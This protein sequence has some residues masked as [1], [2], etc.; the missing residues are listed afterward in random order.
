M[1]IKDA[2][3][4]LSKPLRHAAVALKSIQKVQYDDVDVLFIRS[5]GVLDRNVAHMSTKV[6]LLA[7]ALI[8]GVECLIAQRTTP[9]QLY[10]NQNERVMSLLTLRLGSMG[11]ERGK[12]S[13]D[14]EEELKKAKGMS[15]R[16]AAIEYA[17]K[18]DPNKPHATVLAESMQAFH[19]IPNLDSINSDSHIPFTDLDFDYI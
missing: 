17:Y 4:S 2:V 18:V 15:S 13:E 19:R 9:S 5:D 7:L 10:V 11:L 12:C 1:Y 3:V 14:M 8:L 6:C 16:R